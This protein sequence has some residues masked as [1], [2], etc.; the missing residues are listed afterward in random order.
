MS[1]QPQINPGPTGYAY[2]GMVR[3]YAD[4]GMVD[5]AMQMDDRTVVKEAM[6][7]LA[8]QSPNPD[9]AIAMFIDRFGEEA[10][11][12]LMQKMQ[13]G[14]DG[15]Y[16]QGPGDGLSDS[17]PATVD[18]QQPSALSSGEFVIPADAVS[19]LGNGSNEAGA[20]ELYSMIDRLRQARTG[21]PTPP[22]AIDQRGVMPV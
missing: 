5:P 13:G 22:P 11:Q 2:G 14:M 20:K 15:R 7:A 10:L 21:S 4:G 17:I 9:A 12:A 19:H 16:M 18:G 3:G 1:D 8:G 6:A